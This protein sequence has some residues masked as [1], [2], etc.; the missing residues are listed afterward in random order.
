MDN[1]AMLFF[2][3]SWFFS[4]LAIIGSMFYLADRIISRIIDAT[5]INRWMI[6]QEIENARISLLSEI[7]KTL[8]IETP[9]E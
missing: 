4:A 7:L 3:L 8:P 5:K 1:L 2:Y 6:E 9:E